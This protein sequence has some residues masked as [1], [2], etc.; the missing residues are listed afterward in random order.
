[1]WFA[2]GAAAEVTY[3]CYFP[4]KCTAPDGEC[5]LASV[6]KEFSPNQAISNRQQ[7]G[8]RIFLFSDLSVIYIQENDKT[9]GCSPSDCVKAALAEFLDDDISSV[10]TAHGVCQIGE[11]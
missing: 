11:E 9:N 8:H 5:G 10:A 4:T 6:R 7:N 1:M 3:S 2:S